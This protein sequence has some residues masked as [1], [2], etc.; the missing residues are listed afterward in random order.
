LTFFT[1]ETFWPKMTLFSVKIFDGEK[2]VFWFTLIYFCCPNLTYLGFIKLIKK[3]FFGKTWPRVLSLALCV[4]LLIWR[5]RATPPLCQMHKKTKKKTEKNTGWGAPPPAP[6]KKIE[7][8]E[9]RQKKHRKKIIKNKTPF[10]F[11]RKK[12][13]KKNWKKKFFFSKKNFENIQTFLVKSWSTAR[14]AGC[15]ENIENILYQPTGQLETSLSN[16]RHFRHFP[17][18]FFGEKKFFPTLFFALHQEQLSPGSFDSVFLSVCQGRG[19]GGETEEWRRF[20]GGPNFCKILW[21]WAQ[22]FFGQNRAYFEA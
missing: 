18:F 13:T 8:R 16:I 22:K 11:E 15:V 10:I 5:Q 12:N 3:V 4:L 17:E 19:V 2:K 20:L 14:S 1:I 6:K 21:F 7:L 9:I